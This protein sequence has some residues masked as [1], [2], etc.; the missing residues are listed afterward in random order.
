MSD[1]RSSG[2]CHTF[3]LNQQ[4]MPS[5]SSPIVL[6]L[7]THV[8]HSLYI[9]LPSETVVNVIVN[10]KHSNMSFEENIF[11]TAALHGNFTMPLQCGVLRRELNHLS[12]LQSVLAS[13]L[14]SALK[15]R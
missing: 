13:C 7:R 15:A 12:R 8:F 5:S 14:A 2:F 4:N 1:T 9:Y 3:A 10:G 11:I 6:E